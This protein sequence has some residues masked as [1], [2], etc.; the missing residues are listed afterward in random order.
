LNRNHFTVS[1]RYLF[2]FLAVGFPSAAFP[3]VQLTPP[4]SLFADQSVVGSGTAG[5]GNSASAYDASTIFYNPAGM[6]FLRNKVTITFGG[7][8]IDPNIL[9]NN[10][11]SLTAPGT[12][13]QEPTQG[14]S[15]TKSHDPDFM[16]S[17]VGQFYLAYKLN[18]AL[19][20][21]VGV[22][23][24]FGLETHYDTQSVIRYNATDSRITHVNVNPSIAYKI[25]P[26]LSVGAGIDISHTEVTL[27]DSIDF[28]LNSAQLDQE[29]TTQILTNPGIPAALRPAT[30]AAASSA[31][32]TTVGGITPQGRDGSA[33]L[34]G[35]DT[36]VGWN[37][38][39]LYEPSKGTKLGLSFRS[40]LNNN[41]AGDETYQ[42]VPDYAGVGPAVTTAVTPI[43]GPVGAAQV[44]ASAGTA[45]NSVGAR[46]SDRPISAG[47]LDLP[48]SVSGS[49][50]QDITP[51]WAILGDVTWTRW[52]IIQQLQVDYKDTP[53]L[54]PVPPDFNYSDTLRYSLGTTYGVGT[55]VLRFGMAYENTPVDGQDTRS[56]RLPDNDRT[57][58]GAGAS[59]KAGQN[60][61]IDLAYNHIFF[62]DAPIN[63]ADNAGHVL[64][65]E[66]DTHAD[67]FGLGATCRFG[68]PK[69]AARP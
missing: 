2:L 53:S 5:A 51:A 14:A 48:A 58:I 18:D 39:L 66:F 47:G 20:F 23:E 30:A 35:D 38:A 34:N 9:F 10:Q 12:P 32:A 56:A 28:G 15:S 19:S 61:S 68:G 31:T 60:W 62:K 13:I 8:Y 25:L 67:V 57:T 26:N 64:I 11:G 1:T 44:G 50:V 54:S 37:L 40:M 4:A 33:R 24:P 7:S 6:S 21:G 29:I 22:N 55:A 46:F 63:S 59:I 16:H 45:A 17:T 49:F 36:T 27:E 52:S 42:N 43:I 65:G 69:P 3:Q 41:I